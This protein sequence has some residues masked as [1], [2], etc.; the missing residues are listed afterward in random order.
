MTRR[1]QHNIESNCVSFDDDCYN[2]T[3]QNTGKKI[4]VAETVVTKIR[5]SGSEFIKEIANK[6][7]GK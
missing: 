5:K 7:K 2:E 4:V 1:Q 3:N 6:I